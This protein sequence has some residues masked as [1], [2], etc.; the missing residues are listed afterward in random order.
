MKSSKEKDKMN[1][2][3]SEDDGLLTEKGVCFTELNL[4]IITEVV[5]I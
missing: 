4:Y 3:N 5:K 2:S 1:C